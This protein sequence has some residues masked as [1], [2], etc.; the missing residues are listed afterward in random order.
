MIWTVFN[1]LM[2]YS[3]N[4]SLIYLSCY[5]YSHYLLPPQEYDKLD[6]HIQLPSFNHHF[7]HTSVYLA[8]I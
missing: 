7:H 5:D 4:D 2:S 3:E 8:S 1:L 6:Q